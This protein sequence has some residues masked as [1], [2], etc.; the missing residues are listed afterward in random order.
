MKM[1]II[2]LII[3]FL[4]RILNSMYVYNEKYDY[5]LDK[6]S[7]LDVEISCI[8]KKEE[9]SVTY[10]IKYDGNYFLLSCKN[11]EKTYKNGDKLTIL[12]KVYAIQKNNNPYEFDYK[13]Y[14]NSNG[15]VN[16]IYCNI[17]LKDEINSE[18]IIY[19]IRDMLS[20]KLNDNMSYINS[21]VLKSIMY[22]DDLY[23][24]QDIED[25]F[26]SIGIGHFICV[27]G[28]HIILLIKSFEKIVRTKKFIVL[29]VIL[30]LYFF[31]ICLFN[32]SLLR[33]ICMFLLASMNKNYSYFKRY[34]ISLGIIIMINPYYLFNIGICLSFL[35]VLSI[36]L[37]YSIINSYLKIKTKSKNA[38]LLSIID[39]ISLTLSSQIL[40]IPAQIYCF[41]YVS[42]MSIFSNL[43]LGFLLNYIMEMGFILFILFFI[44]Y[45][46]QLLIQ[47]CN[48]LIEILLMLVDFLYNINLLNI[49]FPRPNIYIIIIY[50][51]L[52][53]LYLYDKKVYIF[54]WSE[55][56]LLRKIVK[57][58]KYV[59]VTYCIGW[60]IYTM[61]FEKSIIFFNV[62]QGNMAY[63]RDGITSVII[64]AGSTR[65][66][67]AGN[68]MINYLKGKNIKH[69]DAILITH[70]HS[71]HIN[72]IE[73]IIK[74]VNVGWIIL[75]NPIERS[76]EYNDLVKTLKNKNIPILYI[77][78]EE[79]IKI[80]K[81]NVDI[82]SP[83][84]NSKITDSDILNA[85]STIYLI[86][87]NYK[88]ALFMGDATKNGEKYILDKYLN[89]DYNNDI[90]E[91]LYKINFYQVS[92]HGSKTSTYEPFISNINN[93]NAIIS[94]DKSV[95]GHPD[96]S[97]VELLK[98]Y[99]FKIFI[100]EQNGAIEF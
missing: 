26:M 5:L 21:N 73:E 50:Y 28:A 47:A 97:V 65:E 20:K 58:F 13:I 48:I 24:D 89:N 63:I 74:N 18:N 42:L 66:N 59:S 70:I 67:N 43:I 71:D 78:Q 17:I 36:K 85:N 75:S 4:F 82:L 30:L 41:G 6:Q 91:K 35:S 2:I 25:K 94:A 7:I 3:L 44:P 37:F 27:S 15:I 9:D 84:V 83:P 77:K 100:T 76:D 56:K 86:E 10:K 72:G 64:D 14:L 19:K 34:A 96:K 39:N 79:K 23:L 69:I 92:H 8:Y 32:I 55:R 38:F 99:S 60:Y 61:F 62:N 52:I 45:I 80:G 49:D 12:G 16:R 88:Y 95:Y 33:A 11:S 1:K 68:I 46:S 57:I 53:I 31:C 90:K 93:C 81:I 22:G 40:I 87:W 29:K 51:V 54:F 98:K